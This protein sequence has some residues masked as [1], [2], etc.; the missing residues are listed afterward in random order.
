M[1]PEQTKI[2]LP[3]HLFGELAKT[4]DGVGLLIKHSVVDELRNNVVKEQNLNANLIQYSDVFRGSLWALSS[5]CASAPGL[6]LIQRVYPE[7]ISWCARQAYE[8]P[9]YSLRGTCVLLLGLISTSEEGRDL[10]GCLDSHNW[11]TLDKENSNICGVCV[12]S[13]LKVFFKSCEENAE[14][15]AV[16]QEKE[17]KADNEQHGSSSSPAQNPC[18]SMIPGN[19]AS[20]IAAAANGGGNNTGSSNDSPSSLTDRQLLKSQCNQVINT[21]AKCVDSITQKEA[22][23]A[24]QKMRHNREFSNVWSEQALFKDVA[25]AMMEG[26]SMDGDVRKFVVFDLFE[27]KE[28]PQVRMTKRK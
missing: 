23:T 6:E 15:G 5:I 2:D 21:L 9:D 12:P 8:S 26:Y 20:N 24:L 19:N 14:V 1:N 16:N 17:K 28:K 13:N 18:L 11:D 10:I 22:V 7:F 27:K 25:L 3:T 4:D